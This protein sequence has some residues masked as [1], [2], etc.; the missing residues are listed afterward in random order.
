MHYQCSKLQTFGPH[1]KWKI[2]LATKIKV[3]SCHL[4]T[5]IL[6]KVANWRP[7]YLKIKKKEPKTKPWTIYWSLV[8]LSN[9]ETI[10]KYTKT[11]LKWTVHDKSNW[12]CLDELH[13]IFLHYVLYLT[14]TFNYAIRSMVTKYL[15]I[16]DVIYN[17]QGFKTNVS[18]NFKW[19]VSPLSRG[20]KSY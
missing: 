10:P 17:T 1:G 9:K 16:L 14:L 7:R 11:Y 19:D 4:V 18:A 5:K 12:F 13:F 6:T 8:Q 15:I 3:K 20:P 2:N